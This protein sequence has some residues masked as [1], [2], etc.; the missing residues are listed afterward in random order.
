MQNLKRIIAFSSFISI[1]LMLIFACVADD[2]YTPP[3]DSCIGEMPTVNTTFEAVKVLYKGEVLQIQEELIIEGYI[4]SSDLTGNFFGSIHFQNH[5]SNPTQGFQLELDLRDLYLFY[6]M[7]QKIYLNLKG[8]YLDNNKGTFKLGGT[9]SAFG[10]LS[11]GRLPATKINEH[12]LVPCDAVS[13]ITPKKY[14]ISELDS[15]M[16]NIL[17]TLQNVELTPASLCSTY[18]EPQKAKTHILKD[19]EGNEVFMENSGF[20]DFQAALLPLGNGTITGVLTRNQN[21]YILT[22]RD[23]EDVKMNNV[24]CGGIEYYCETPVANTT[25]QSIKEMYK[26]TSITLKV[27]LVIKVV[28][29][30]NDSSGNFYKE[31]YVQDESGGINIKIEEIALF[32]TFQLNHEITIAVNGITLHKVDGEF[33]L[34]VLKDDAFSGIQEEDF[35]RFFYL[36][37]EAQHITPKAIEIN[38]ISEKDLGSLVA[39]TSVQFIEESTFV[40]S[41]KDTKSAV[42]D[43]FANEIFVSTSRRFKNGDSLLPQENGIII[44]ILQY[45]GKYQLRIRN[46]EDVSQMNTERCNVL[47]NATEISLETLLMGF[48]ETS[49]EIVEN[50]KIRGIITSNYSTL[51]LEETKAIMQSGD[52]GIELEFDAPHQLKVNSKIEIALRGL[53]IKKDKNGFLLTN[54]TSEHILSSV[55]GNTIQPEIIGLEAFLTGNYQNKLVQINNFQF[56]DLNS[57]YGGENELT[58]CEDQFIISISNTATFS[59]VSVVKGRGNVV[60]IPFGNNLYVR[61]AMD[62]QFT[63]SYEDCSLKNTSTSILISEIADPD[64]SNTTANMR[65]IELFNAGSEPVSLSGWS[66][67]RYTNSNTEF[68][69]RSVID[70]TGY[71]MAP[72]SAFVIA[73]DA[74]SFEVVYG[75]SPDLE[76]GTGG[77]AD[78]NGDDTMHLVDGNGK[79]VDVFG[80]PGEDGSGTNHEFED[81][82]AVRNTAVVK[83]NTD[84]TFSEWTIYNDT[85]A[86]GT[87][88]EP[89]TAPQDFN[90][91]TR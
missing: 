47:Q 75:F 20:A 15:T 90:P 16:V 35:Y 31:I 42:T 77:A 21:N 57:T 17:V 83:N 13:V 37:E 62:F 27:P 74:L 78:S 60:G 26:E 38:A 5:P 80:V 67:R 29:T 65:F 50:I 6:P 52:V 9:F 32:E 30:A 49:E 58:N 41:N 34:G 25:I 56:K 2:E 1:T 23:L 59:N 55:D 10:N 81:G 33:V 89:K 73:A 51:N 8:L 19:C 46:L 48:G 22:V 7:G 61:D 86:D 14:L 88:N 70:L 3:K 72:L 82:R 63:D 53:R 54:I 4:N 85:G 12:I 76:G 40:V 36:G 43:C 91:K 84:Y 45:D 28:I 68:T 69:A 24:R 11:V 79:V 39:I 44:G 66:L 71:T 18:A 64:N 87:I